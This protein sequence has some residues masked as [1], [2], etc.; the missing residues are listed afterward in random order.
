MMLKIYVH[1]RVLSCLHL[2]SLAFAQGH[3]QEIKIPYCNDG[4]LLLT[5]FQ[6]NKSTF[7]LFGM[8]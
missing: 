4:I 3:D 2:L 7:L 6:L 5:L 1:T 8:L